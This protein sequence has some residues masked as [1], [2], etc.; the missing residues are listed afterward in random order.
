M[1]PF[2]LWFP[3]ISNMYLS[4][5]DPLPAYKLDTPIRN[6]ILHTRWKQEISN[7]ILDN[8]Q[9][10]DRPS[11]RE[12]RQ[13]ILGYSTGRTWFKR[14]KITKKIQVMLAAGPPVSLPILF[15]RSSKI[16]WISLISCIISF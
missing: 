15:S 7:F 10:K 6:L 2:A 9:E 5:L 14:S 1:D 13:V 12:S 11:T 16:L 3:M 8:Y 4:I